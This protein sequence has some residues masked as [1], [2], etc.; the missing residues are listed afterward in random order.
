[1]AGYDLDEYEDYYE[2]EGGEYEEDGE[3]Y[4]EV[5]EEEEHLPTQEELEYLELRQKLKD[6]YRKQSKKEHGSGITNSQEKK[7]KLPYQ[8]FGSFFGPSQPVIAPR[9]IQECKSLLENPRLAESILKSKNG[10]KG[11]S[12]TP[13]VSKPR[14]NGNHQPS[15]ID[16]MAKP[17]AKIQML[18]NTRDYSFLLSDDAELPIPP[19]NPPKC[20][21]ARKSAEEVR[22]QRHPDNIGRNIING[23]EERKPVV[24]SSE[25]R[26]KAGQQ[27]QRPSTASKLPA[28]SQDSRKQVGRNEGS[29]PG[30]PLASHDNRKQVG[31]NEGSGPGRPLA[32]HDSRKQVGRNEGS[33]LGRP[34][35]SHDSRKQVSRNEGSGPGQPLTSQDSR[36]QVG[37]N[38][39]NVLSRPSG[40]KT[41]PSKTTVVN[42][43]KVMASSVGRGSIPT[44]HIPRTSRPLPATL[45]KPL[46]H[47]DERGPSNGN[48]S[49]KPVEM[50][51]SQIKQQPTRPPSNGQLKERQQ[52]RPARPFDDDDDVDPND[53]I[54]SIR[55]MM[56]YNPN[57]YRG[58]KDDTKDMVVD[59]DQILREEKR[60]ERIGRKEDEEE[61]RK[62][63]EEDRRRMA[64]KKRKLN[65]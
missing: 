55:K 30:R 56:G 39:G 3:E 6:E 18:K 13:G 62:L 10:I 35:A 22:S 44:G 49:R 53:P 14:P 9:V 15:K 52:K 19:K 38:A 58:I 21:P 11:G 7:P 8:K 40:Q 51:R 16:S 54:G 48:M 32:S 12:V 59:F 64:A 5:D 46:D 27:V 17:K 28:T 37:R 43:Q 2:D 29:G 20:V 36:K 42:R 24:T 63:E 41:V 33:G 31:R 65:H 47:R 26:L 25:M 50:S 61:A 23:R 1:M 34:L 4:E 60:S 45:K 57:K